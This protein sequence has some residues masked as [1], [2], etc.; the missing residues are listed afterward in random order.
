MVGSGI[1][2]T[3]VAGRLRLAQTMLHSFGRI[4]GRKRER[5]GKSGQ[6]TGS[7]CF[8]KALLIEKGEEAVD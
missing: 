5:A 6:L 8:A 2:L 1:D 7:E 4:A 3:A